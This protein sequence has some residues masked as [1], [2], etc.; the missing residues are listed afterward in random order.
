MDR[1]L[2]TS[3]LAAVAALA[4]GVA[5]LVLDA[6]VLGVV[7]GGL[8]LLTGIAAAGLAA[9]LRDRE[10]RVADLAADAARLREEMEALATLLETSQ[11][12]DRPGDAPAPNFESRGTAVE[13]AKSRHPASSLAPTDDSPP[14][15]VDETHF[16]T[17]LHQRVASAR[18]HLHPLSVVIFAVAGGPGLDQRLDTLAHVVLR[19]LR[20]C[21][22]VARVNDLMLSAVLDGSS[23]HGA[24]WAVERVRA[25]LADSPE[26]RPVQLSAGIA[27]YPTHA[28]EPDALIRAAGRALEIARAAGASE[29]QV[30]DRDT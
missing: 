25:A 23:E 29:V 3:V 8:G 14:G 28:L 15:L 21:D 19:T 7:A 5:G 10:G 22:S 11:P 13:A 24:V 9:R 1:R 18:R 16:T 6:P 20:E 12:R 4:A 26:D 17:V 27:C 2:V 30:A